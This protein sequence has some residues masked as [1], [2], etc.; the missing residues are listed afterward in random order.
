M[1]THCEVFQ[2]MSRAKIHDLKTCLASGM[3]ETA[4]VSQESTPLA[5]RR[6]R[7]HSCPMLF[8]IELVLSN[9]AKSPA[10]A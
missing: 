4:N 10:M 9:T 2:E 7:K 6:G 1:S 8:R 3:L 5:P